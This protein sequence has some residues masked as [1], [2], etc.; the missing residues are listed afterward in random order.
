VNFVIENAF[1]KTQGFLK[2]WSFVLTAIIKPLEY[3]PG[4]IY[5]NIALAD[6]S[7]LHLTIWIWESGC[8][9]QS[10]FSV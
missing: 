9:T 8:S 1:Q 7:I 5:T 6:K 3:I 4:T 10:V 2:A